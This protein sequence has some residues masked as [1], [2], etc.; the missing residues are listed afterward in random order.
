MNGFVGNM[1][2]WLQIWRHFGYVKLQ[3][4]THFGREVLIFFWGGWKKT[5]QG[6]YRTNKKPG[7]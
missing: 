2:L 6:F 3:G 7:V 1:Y 4:G 5:A